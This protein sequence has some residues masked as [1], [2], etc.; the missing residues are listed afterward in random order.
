MVVYIPRELVDSFKTRNSDVVR[1]EEE[2][3]LNT[4]HEQPYALVPRVQ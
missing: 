2:R 4:G 1:L 3:I